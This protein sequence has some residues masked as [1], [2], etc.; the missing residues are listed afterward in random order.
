[1][2]LAVA[3]GGDFVSVTLF[4]GGFDLV[5]F[6]E[7]LEEPFGEVR[8]GFE[9]FFKFTPNVGEAGGTAGFPAPGFLK[10]AVFWVNFVGVASDD[11]F[12]V[13]ADP[14]KE[15]LVVAPERPVED[16]VAIEALVEPEAPASGGAGFVGIAEAGLGLI[17][18]SARPLRAAFGCLCRSSP[19]VR[20]QVSAL[21]HVALHEVDEDLALV[22]EVEGTVAHRLLGEIYSVAALVEFALAVVWEVVEEAIADDFGKKV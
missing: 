4:E 10:A 14:I 11:A 6:A 9:G 17:L 3:G 13:L 2:F 5:K 12:E 16:D 22:G 18:A 8:A 21:E 1:V 19:F 20:S 7:N 15:V